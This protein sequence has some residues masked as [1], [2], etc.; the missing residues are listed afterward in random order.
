MPRRIVVGIA[1]GVLA[2]LGAWIAFG[3]DQ[4]RAEAGG[5]AGADQI[6]VGG[7]VLVL[8][9][10]WITFRAIHPRRRKRDP[11]APPSTLG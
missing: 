2:F 11:E 5:G 8:A 7:L 9:G 3:A 10:V 4:V 6:G 1:G